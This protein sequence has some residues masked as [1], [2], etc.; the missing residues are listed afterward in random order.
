MRRRNQWVGP[1]IRRLGLLTGLLILASGA[2]GC[3]G[4]DGDSLTARNKAVVR[5]YLEE[6]VNRGDWSKWDGYFGD[7][8]VFNGREMTREDFR[9]IVAHFRSF[10]P[11]FA[12]TIEEQIAEGDKVATRVTCRGTHRGEIEGIAPTGKRVEFWGFAIDRL[13]DGKVVEMWHEV[14]MNGLLQELRAQ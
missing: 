4:S 13:V 10:L 5:G 2:P 1:L 11:D 3:I 6:I 12:L 9:A 7:R 8:V 14:D